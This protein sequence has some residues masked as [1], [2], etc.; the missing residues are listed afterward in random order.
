MLLSSLETWQAMLDSVAILQ[1]VKR[2]EGSLMMTTMTM[3]VKVTMMLKMTGFCHFVGCLFSGRLSR[4]H[5]A[6]WSRGWH[7]GLPI[8]RFAVQV[9]VMAE[10]SWLLLP[11]APQSTQLQWVH[12]VE[13]EAAREMLAAASFTR[14]HESLKT[15]TFRPFDGHWAHG[16][17]HC[18]S[19]LSGIILLCVLGSSMC[20]VLS[21]S[22]RCH[23]TPTGGICSCPSGYE[24][25]PSNNQTCRGMILLICNTQFQVALVTD[26]KWREWT[27][28]L[29]R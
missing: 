21:C 10:T 25:D 9:L 28:L 8:L 16:V 24:I 29:I 12:Q 26:L 23:S 22:H 4:V 20:G 1:R 19:Y 18:L 13:V 27:K 3:T 17:C 14:C 11:Q 6:Q 15:L 7:T 2:P 5:T